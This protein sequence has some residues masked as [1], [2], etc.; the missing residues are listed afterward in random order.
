MLDIGSPQ[1]ICPGRMCMSHLA[2]AIVPGALGYDAKLIKTAPK[3]LSSSCFLQ[4]RR[5]GAVAHDTERHAAPTAYVWVQ[6][7]MR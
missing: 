7:S 1:A 4:G 5:P 2:H 6:T 3:P